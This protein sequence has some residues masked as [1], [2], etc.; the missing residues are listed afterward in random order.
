MAVYV[1]KYD[2]I[3]A[4]ESSGDI[5]D[6]RTIGV[7]VKRVDKLPMLEKNAV[8]SAY[9]AH[10]ALCAAANVAER[11]KEAVLSKAL[12]EADAIL[13]KVL[14]ERGADNE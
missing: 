4:L 6:R 9:K 1:K 12:R 2:V 11:N 5:I 14:S 8:G 10:W 13:C 3:D 7:L